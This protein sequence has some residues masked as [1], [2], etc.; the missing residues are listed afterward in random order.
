MKIRRQ[1]LMIPLTAFLYNLFVYG[2]GR[3]LSLGKPHLCLSTA[4]DEAIPFLPWMV[5]IYMGWPLFWAVNYALSAERSRQEAIRLLSAHILGQ[6][7]CFFSF[8]FFPTTMSRPEISGNTLFDWELSLVY[9]LDNP[10]N[11][12]PSIHCLV[13][14]LCWISVRRNRLVPKWYQ[15]FSLM[16]ASAVCISTLTVKQHVIADVI[17]G[18]AL[19]EVSYAAAGVLPICRKPLP[20]KW[21]L[22]HFL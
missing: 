19:A 14:W 2:V 10:D 1:S 13:S 9:K 15:L 17:T 12:L 8:I 6:T 20:E 11:L 7:V 22:S 4:W 21:K 18:I 5:L 16:F 3:L